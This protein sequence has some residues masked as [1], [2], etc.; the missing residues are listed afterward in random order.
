MKHLSLPIA[1]VLGLLIATYAAT[2]E[3]LVRHDYL[4]LRLKA[5]A[6]QPQFDKFDED[7]A[8]W[9][10]LDDDGDAQTNL[11][12]DT[13]TFK[14]VVDGSIEEAAIECPAADGN[15]GH[16]VSYVLPVASATGTVPADAN[17]CSIRFKGKPATRIRV[18]QSGTARPW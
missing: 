14:E 7:I 12:R 16:V 8:T 15:S 10:Q 4:S 5:K 9:L 2:A 6:L 11:F 3:P 17:K 13:L 1:A 18:V